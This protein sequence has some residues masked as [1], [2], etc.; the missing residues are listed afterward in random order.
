MKHRTQAYLAAFLIPLLLGAVMGSILYSVM[1]AQA[2]VSLPVVLLVF[3]LALALPCVFLLRW[4]F[5]QMEVSSLGLPAELREQLEPEIPMRQFDLLSHAYQTQ[6]QAFSDMKVDRFLSKLISDNSHTHV[7]EDLNQHLLD[8][9]HSEDFGYRY[10]YFCLV[11]IEMEDYESY[12]L[13]DCNGHLFLDD[14][15]RMYEV[16]DHAFAARLGAHHQAHSVEVKNACVFLVNLTG[17]TLDTPR[18]ALSS[19]VD[20]L[21]GACMGTICNLTEAFNLNVQ[22]TVSAA[23]CDVMETHSTFAWL[24]TYREYAEFTGSAKPVLGPQDF[25]SL[26]SLSHD[27]PSLVEKSYYSA[28]LSFDYSQAEQ[29]LYTLERYLLAQDSLSVAK[30]KLEMSQCLSTAEEVAFSQSSEGSVQSPV[31]DWSAELAACENQHQLEEL[32]HAFFSSLSQRTKETTGESAGTACQIA[33]YLDQNYASDNLSIA[34]VADAFSLSQSYISRIFK[35]QYGRS[36][37]DYIHELRVEQAKKLLRTT[38][39]SINEIAEQVGYSTP[40]TLNR[41]FKRLVDM[42]P[43]AYRQLSQSH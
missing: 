43:G 13:K 40:W 21:C 16:V 32:I 24:K 30:L 34:T 7:I 35:K 15:R 39:L 2:N 18:E 29:A 37:P 1:K 23:F 11:Y 12:M 33:S 25:E 6:F 22:A 19:Q 27:A 14:F 4:F 36:I 41:I 20:H 9:L 31:Q 8:I 28:L 10:D 42:T 26:I 5:H 17:S 3:A 38:S